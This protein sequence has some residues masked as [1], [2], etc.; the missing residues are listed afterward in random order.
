MKNVRNILIIDS[1]GGIVTGLLFLFLQAFVVDW[2]GWS[3]DHV[4]FVGIVHITYGSYSGLLVLGYI[5]RRWLPTLH[6]IFLIIASA[7]WAGQSYTQ[8]YWLRDSASHLGLIHLLLEGTYL[9]VLAYIE[10]LIV[11]P[12]VVKK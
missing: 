10:A 9:F 1:V 6:L 4:L 12:H 3:P 5:R 2:Y 11:L 7:A 8:F